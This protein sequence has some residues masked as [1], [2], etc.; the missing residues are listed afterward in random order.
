MEVSI[1][2]LVAPGK[3]AGTVRVWVAVLGYGALPDL[4]WTV[5]GAA[6]APQ[7]VLPLRP[8]YPE[9]GSLRVA[10]GVVDLIGLPADRTTRTVRV[11]ASAPGVPPVDCALAVRSVPAEVP[12]DGSSFN[13]LLVSCFYRGGDKAGRCGVVVDGLTGL[14]RPDVVLTVG[15]QVYLDQPPLIGSFD[16]ERLAATFAQKYRDNFVGTDGYAAVLRAAAVAAIP[17]DHEY[18]N[19]YPHPAVL[20]LQS[21]WRRDDLAQNPWRRAARAMYDAFQLGSPDGYSTRFDVPPLSFFMMDNRTF[22]ATDGET[23]LRAADLQRYRDWVE[24]VVADRLVPVL[25]TGPSLLQPVKHGWDKVKDRNFANYGDYGAVMDGL[26]GLAR[27]G[28]GVLAL[29]GDVHYGRVTDARIFGTTPEAGTPFGTI[30]EVISS[31]TALVWGSDHQRADV[32]P[33]HFAPGEPA[34]KLDTSATWPAPADIRGDHV[35]LLKFTRN[36]GG[37]ALEVQ[38]RMIREVHGPKRGSYALPPVVLPA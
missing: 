28:R 18:W 22:R 37:V 3:P 17:D 6:V 4:A 16:D 10:T 27:R 35:A 26:T 7:P 36:A 21:L 5:D 31:P 13:V 1:R 2:P 30:R 25:V 33:T 23:T 11:V 12:R 24:D 20:T 8:A 38:Y 29:T 19:N 32:P 14:D 9:A 34:V 15:D